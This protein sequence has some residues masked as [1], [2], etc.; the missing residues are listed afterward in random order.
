LFDLNGYRVKKKILQERSRRLSYLGK[1]LA[2]NTDFL[3]AYKLYAISPGLNIQATL[4]FL[5]KY[6]SR[7]SIAMHGRQLNLLLES[8]FLKVLKAGNM[9]PCMCLTRIKG[10]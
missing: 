2:A 6:L 9:F 8:G 3:E 4:M 1:H 5:F 10:G 7:V